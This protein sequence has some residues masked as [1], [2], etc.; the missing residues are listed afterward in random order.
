MARVTG[1]SDDLPCFPHTSLG[2][3]IHMLYFF[4]ISRF[5]FQ[6]TVRCKFPVIAVQRFDFKISIIAI[7][8]FIVISNPLS[9]E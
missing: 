2:G 8:L 6:S 9:S 7:Q 3:F 4:K 5:F 1:V